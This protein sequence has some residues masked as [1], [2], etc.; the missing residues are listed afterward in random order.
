MQMGDALQIASYGMQAQSDRLRVVAENL[1]NAETTA[2]APGVAPYQRRLV[3]FQNVMDKTLGIPVVK[4]NYGVDTSAF[5]Q[6]FDPNHPAADG[7]GY[8]LMPNVNSVIELTDLR[9]ARRGYEAN[10]N[11]V[12][13][14]RGMLQQTID[15]LK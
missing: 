7:N 9:E 12:Q 1:A 15:L 2:P 4:T 13:V 3:T 6:K 8:V 14:T 10:L 5:R 11:V